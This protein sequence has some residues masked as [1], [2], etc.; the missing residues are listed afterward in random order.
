ME[1]WTGG[2]VSD[3]EYTGGFHLQQTPAYLQ[4]VCLLNGIEPP[5]GPSFACC[6][7]GCG[8]GLTAAVL[9]AS[10]P[11]S[12]FYAIDFNPAHIARAESLARRA[13]LANL[14]FIESGF[15]ELIE[16]HGPELPRFDFLTLH[17][18]YS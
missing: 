9:A 1:T 12:T 16:D 6:E 10:N 17:G 15:A 7:L 5:V 8:Q 4:F 3:V 11:Q 18:V 14:S 2:Y 13:R